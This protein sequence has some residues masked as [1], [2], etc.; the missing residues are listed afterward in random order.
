MKNFLIIS[1]IIISV[2]IIVPRLIEYN[3]P[4]TEKIR[5]DK[6]DYKTVKI[7][8]NTMAYKE[9]GKGKPVIL[10]HGYMNSTIAWE[11]NIDVLVKSGY[12]V[13]AVDLLGHGM[14]DK[15]YDASYTISFYSKQILDFMDK[16]GIKSADF[17]G[18]SMGGAVSI[19]TV[20]VKPDAVQKLVLIGSA[21]GYVLGKSSI[22]PKLVK[23]PYLGEFLLQIASRD[24]VL[25][26]SKF[27][28]LRSDH[29][30]TVEYKD[31][32]YEP[33]KSRGYVNMSLKIARSTD[34]GEWNLIDC[35]KQI[36][37]RTLIIH[38]TSD[39]VIKN[40]SADIMKKNIRNSTLVTLDKGPHNL[41][42]SDPEFVNA[43]I[44]KFLTVK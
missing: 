5:A 6:K 1:S 27:L 26:V 40:Q 9:F 16:A 14:S 39:F 23:I 4:L 42:E 24:I 12:H 13:Y 33:F 44:I 35:M 32:Y 43:E 41:M 15:P 3:K 7:G 22:I 36:E 21:G 20:C 19:K 10:I 28:S 37:S 11:R 38:G 17:I 25:R 31:K 30:F 8:N 34:M 18:H 2:V 29:K